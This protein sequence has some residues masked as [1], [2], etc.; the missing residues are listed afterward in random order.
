M[1][2]MIAIGLHTWRNNI[3][4]VFQ[5]LVVTHGNTTARRSPRWQM[6]QFCIQN[7]CLQ[8]VHAAVD[9]LH[10]VIAFSA[11]PSE[12]CHPAGKTVVIGHSASGIPIRTQV[13]SRIKGERRNVAEGSYKLSLIAGEMRLGAIF[14]NPQIMLSCDRHDRAHVRRLPVEVNGNDTDGGRRDLSFDISGIN[15][16][17]FLVR[18][19][20]HDSAA[21]LRYCL[22]G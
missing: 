3:A 15:G 1:I 10:D 14:Y 2:H 12:C 6:W 4:H 21:S 7:S 20:K 13:F 9:P 19:T 5:K 11:V 17:G 18:V 22:G 16:E 8:P